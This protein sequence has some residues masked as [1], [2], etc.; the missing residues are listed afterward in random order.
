MKR[1]ERE[2]KRVWHAKPLQPMPRSGQ[3]TEEGL[4]P[5]DRAGVLRSTPA[6]KARGA[7]RASVLAGVAKH[8]NAGGAS[9]Q[10][11]RRT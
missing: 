3:E 1:S 10:T 5:H 6:L 4:Y 2:V 9:G 11:E 8:P 7:D